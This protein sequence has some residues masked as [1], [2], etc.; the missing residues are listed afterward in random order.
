MKQYVNVSLL[1]LLISESI[2]LIANYV[3]SKLKVIL[4]LLNIY[5]TQIMRS[6]FSDNYNKYLKPNY[7]LNNVTKKSLSANKLPIAYILYIIYIYILLNLFLYYKILI[8]FQ[9]FI[10]LML[11]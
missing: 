5:I 1:A 10:L 4:Y 2:I 8:I 6:K 7:S 3:S 11:L 9:K